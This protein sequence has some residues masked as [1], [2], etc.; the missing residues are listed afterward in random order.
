[1]RDGRQRVPGAVAKFPIA[2]PDGPLPS[3]G[4]AVMILAK[5]PAKRARP[6]SS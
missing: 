6:G 4:T 3:G 5:D 2:A 1:M